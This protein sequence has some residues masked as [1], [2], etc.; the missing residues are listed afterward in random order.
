MAAAAILNLFE[1]KIAPLDPPS[2][3]TPPYKQ[4]WSGSDDRL[5]RYSHLKFFQHGDGRHLGFVRTGN[6]AISSAVPENPTLEPNM[7]WIGSPVAE[8]WPFAYIGGIRNPHFWGRGSRRGSA[9]TPLERAMVVSYSL[10]IVT[11]A[12]S[13]TI[14]QQFAIECL[15]RSNQQGVGSV[16]AQIWGC[17]PWCRPMMYGSA[18]SEHPKLTNGVT[19]FEE[20]QPMWSQSTNVTDRQTDGQTD[21]QHAITIPRFALTCIAR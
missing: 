18:E 17:S 1:S 7:K 8:I 13:V 15:R 14:R 3:K 20:F 19:N 11:I 2:P 9:M 5:R 12:I 21:R 4:T 10:S 16:W 6:S